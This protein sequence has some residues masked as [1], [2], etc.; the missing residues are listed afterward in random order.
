VEPVSVLAIS[1]ASLAE[2]ALIAPVHSPMCV[3]D[4]IPPDLVADG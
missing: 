2:G 1:T 4:P 3:E